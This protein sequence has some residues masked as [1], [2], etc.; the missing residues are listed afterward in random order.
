MPGAS[1][2]RSSEWLERARAER[3]GWLTY[4]KVEPLL[5]PIR[6]DPRFA[7]LLRKMRLD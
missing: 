7:E 5:E 6:G 2:S 1:P 3:R 4:L